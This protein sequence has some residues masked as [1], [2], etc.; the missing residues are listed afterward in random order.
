MSCNDHT[1]ASTFVKEE[2]NYLCALLFFCSFSWEAAAV[3]F[4]KFYVNLIIFSIHCPLTRDY[5]Q[6]F[7]KI[8]LTHYGKYD[9]LPPLI[10]PI[11]LYASLI[12][13]VAVVHQLA[14][15]LLDARM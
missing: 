10:P 4:M 12:L 1:T 8:P 7:P 14:L 3:Q 11:H 6:N 9:I 15:S 5:H 13:Q 2:F